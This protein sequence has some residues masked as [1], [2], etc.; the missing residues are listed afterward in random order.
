MYLYSEYALQIEELVK[1]YDNCLSI[2]DMWETVDKRKLIATKLGKGVVRL[3][4]IAGV[5]GREWVNTKVLVNILK[6]YCKMYMDSVVI[7][8]DGGLDVRRLL[9]R[10][11]IIFIPLVNPDGY[12]IAT[13]GFYAIKNKELRERCQSLNIDCRYWKYNARGIDI[14]RNFRCKSYMKK[15]IS[16]YPFS[17]NESIWLKKM[18]DKYR[19]DILIDIHSRGEN[20]FYYR[21]YM[22]K[23]Y[24]INQLKWAKY[25][26]N[27][28]G[29]RLS[30][31]SE[32]IGEK[33]C[34]GNTVHYYSEYVK[35]AAIT[36]ETV[37][38]EEGIPIRSKNITEV[39]DKLMWLPLKVL[40]YVEG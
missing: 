22:N 37:S 27:I 17:E 32:E 28:T 29:Y 12:A 24:N 7:R 39:T 23:E 26:G 31:P 4:I 25:I 1:V 3:I 38:E 21:N 11:S 5:H 16:D 19:A 13:E 18:F 6:F 2:I 8:G 35:N 30:E 15:V 34:G 20:I 40:N 36:I 14:N 9:D 10:R 33:D